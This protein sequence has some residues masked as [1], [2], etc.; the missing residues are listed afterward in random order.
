MNLLKCFLVLI[1]LGFVFPA[2][3]Q[4]PCVHEAFSVDMATPVSSRINW[5][6]D[7]VQAILVEPLVLPDNTTLPAGALLKGKVLDVKAS[8]R[9]KSGVIRLVFEIKTEARAVGLYSAKIDT[10]D[11]WLRQ[12]D[13]NTSV[14]QV[15]PNHS[16]RLL[17]Q[18]IQ[19]RLGSDRA[20]WASVLGINENFIPNPNSD[21]FMVRYNRN[22]VLVGAGD[23]LK[24]QLNCP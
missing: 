15:N 22:D 14:W 21:A 3:A 5:V 4:T 17:N 20:V 6:G 24:L 10:Q 2:E 8:E 18:R 12:T 1:A 23:T 11:G 16:T 7:P 13:Q 9:A 19:Q